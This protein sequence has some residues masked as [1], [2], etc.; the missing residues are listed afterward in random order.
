M[1]FRHEADAEQLRAWLARHA[2]ELVGTAN[3]ELL[4]W[5]LGE[6]ADSVHPH[7][8]QASGEV[9]GYAAR[10]LAMHAV[11][12]GTFDLILDGG[13]ATHL[14][15]DALLDA[16]SC[17]PEPPPHDSV[18]ADAFFAHLGG[19]TPAGQGEWVAWLHLMA[20][21]RGDAG[22]RPVPGG[23]RRATALEGALGRLASSGWLPRPLH[24][25]G[26][27]GESRDRAPGR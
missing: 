7:G 1:R 16:A 15:P 17:L 20:T 4:D 26:V 12:A 11:N 6:L 27:R 3:G 21:A 22:G 25:A 9:G 14:T 23:R 13:R 19:V 2:Q 18:A 24:R 5:L 8:W 10:A